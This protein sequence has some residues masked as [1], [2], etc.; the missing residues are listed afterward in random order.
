MHFDVKLGLFASKLIDIS[1]SNSKFTGVHFNF[2]RVFSCCKVH[3]NANYRK[4]KFKKKC[5]LGFNFAV[6][7]RNLRKVFE[8]GVGLCITLS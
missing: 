7:D 6:P 1:E 8:S 3:I 2:G 4:N 5:T